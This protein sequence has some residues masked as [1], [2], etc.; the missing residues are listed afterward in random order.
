MDYHNL[1]KEAINSAEKLTLPRVTFLFPLMIAFM[2]LGGGITAKMGEMLSQGTKYLTPLTQVEYSFRLHGSFFLVLFWIVYILFFIVSFWARRDRIKAYRIHSYTGI[3]MF[4]PTFYNMFVALQYFIPFLIV[5]VFYWLLFIVAIVRVGYKLKRGESVS[6]SF[7]IDKMKQFS[8]IIAV[9]WVMYA[10]ANLFLGGLDQVM[11]RLILS[12]LP[13][14]PPFLILFLSSW[15][16]SVFST[17]RALK[18]IEQNQEKYRL[19]LGYSVKDWYGKKS[20]E[21]RVELR[22]L[23]ENDSK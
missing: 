11:A 7:T 22:K 21:Y 18:H 8:S 17:I 2:L 3:I 14:A 4:T 23:K 10:G 15:Y 20:K 5:R 19:E 1:S 13:I 6:I 16:Q 9:L 12:L